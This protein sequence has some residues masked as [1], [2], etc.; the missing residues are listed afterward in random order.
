[1][2]SF[3][4]GI[5]EGLKEGFTPVD[6]SYEPDR[7]Y[8]LSLKLEDTPEAWSWVVTPTDSAEIQKSLDS[9]MAK[10]YQPMG[11][12]R[13]PSNLGTLVVRFRGRPA[14]DWKM[15]SYASPEEASSGIAERLA[16]GQRP[17]GLITGGKSAN[18]M[19]TVPPATVDGWQV[20]SEPSMSLQETE[21]FILENYCR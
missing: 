2:D 10:G 3:Q 6:V 8:V 5:N 13:L 19:F 15:A 14:Q 17:W 4:Q 1:M 11:I 20:P 12:T 16:Q 21:A 9:W 7:L 18:V